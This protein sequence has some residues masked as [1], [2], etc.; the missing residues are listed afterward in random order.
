MTNLL[1]QAM[2]LS[3]LGWC[4]LPVHHRE[5]HPSFQWSQFQNR[6][7]S[8]EELR[9]WFSTTDCGMAVVCGSISGNL[10]VMDFDEPGSYE[11]WRSEN[12]D[13]ASQLPTDKRGDR[14]HVFVKTSE[15]VKSQNLFLPGFG[16]AGEFLAEGKLAVIPPTVHHSGVTRTW[17]IEPD[18]HVPMVSLEELGIVTVRAH[19][20]VT[21]PTRMIDGPI[22]QGQRHKTLLSLSGKLRAQGHGYGLILDILSAVNDARCNPALPIEEVRK[23]AD[24]AS[25]QETN[26]PLGNGTRDDGYHSIPTVAPSIITD[27]LLRDDDGTERFGHLFKACPE[28]LQD[29]GPAD[30]SFIVQDLLPES[31]LVV[32]G[33]TSKAGKSCF[34]TALSMAVAEGE[35]F[36]GLETTKGAVLWCAYEESEQERG[37][38]LR[39]FG[40][41]PEGL[42][43]T[44][45]K[46]HIDKVD[47]IAALRFWIRKTGAKLLV[48]DPLYGANTAESLSDGRTARE[49]LAGLKELC[50]TE[51]VCAIVIHHFNKAVANG[52]TRER[53]ADSNQILATASMDLL[54][55]STEKEDG[56]REIRLQ[57]RGRGSFANNTWLIKS[58]GLASFELLTTGTAAAVTS[59][60]KAEEILRVLGESE[61]PMTAEAV[62]KVVGQKLAT[63]R[64]RLTTMTKEGLVEQCGTFM[65]AALYRLAGGQRSME[66][67]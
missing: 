16:R 30:F 8:E 50:R 9:R 12:P 48:I 6:E 47:G 23:I 40:K 29:I 34:V 65:R 60:F 31:Y 67:A 5:K 41:Q 56:S 43:I 36:L 10:A 46:V 2:K 52:V 44:H 57:G 54:M 4:I 59:Q 21:T 55:D 26:H 20:D 49:T 22:P 61:E 24:W 38:A 14:Y 66:V 3:E 25:K 32:L 63:V 39:E 42:Y 37:F 28:Y 45:E 58:T 11:H 18:G 33:G 17:T 53:F 7:P 19:A 62:S 51:S 35:P 64:N 27:Y 1:Q 13:L 15:P